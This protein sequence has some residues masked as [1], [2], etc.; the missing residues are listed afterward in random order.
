MSTT[1]ILTRDSHFSCS[2]KEQLKLQ[3][4]SGPL[5]DLGEQVRCRECLSVHSVLF[6]AIQRSGGVVGIRMLRQIGLPTIA[7]LNGAI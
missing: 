5:E 2:S 7:P 6:A 4:I 1:P 3:A